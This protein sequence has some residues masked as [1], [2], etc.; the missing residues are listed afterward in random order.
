LQFCKGSAVEAGGSVQPAGGPGAGPVAQAA[1]DVEDAAD[2]RLG[3]PQRVDE[4][5]RRRAGAG[6]V[7]ATPVGMHSGCV[8]PRPLACTLCAKSWEITA[9]LTGAGSSLALPK[10]SDAGTLVAGT[11]FN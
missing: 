9:G 7:S 4:P 8:D 6:T 10:R 11:P 5:G 2:R 3:D 1:D